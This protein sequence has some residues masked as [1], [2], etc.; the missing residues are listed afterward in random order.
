MTQEEER[1]IKE[2]YKLDKV[3]VVPPLISIK[4]T[5]VVRMV[6]A[7]KFMGVY[8]DGGESPWQHNAIRAYEDREDEI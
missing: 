6:K 3:E 4:D 5:Q 1:Q 8:D 2:Y 7:S